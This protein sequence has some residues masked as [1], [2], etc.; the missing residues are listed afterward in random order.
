MGHPKA[1]VKCI[2]CQRSISPSQTSW[3]LGCNW[4]DT[5]EAL[6]RE[7]PPLAYCATCKLK[8]DRMAAKLL[9]ANLWRWGVQRAATSSWAQPKLNLIVPEG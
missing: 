1:T 6:W 5:G 9:A 8:F 2:R 3:F 4:M 7:D